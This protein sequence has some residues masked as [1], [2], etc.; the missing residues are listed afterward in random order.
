MQQK[1]LA[2]AFSI[3]ARVHPL[4]CPPQ[5]SRPAH[6]AAAAEGGEAGGEARVCAGLALLL[7]VDL[8]WLL[9][10]AG[11][12][13]V[14][15][16]R[17]SVAAAAAVAATTVAAAA[18]I[19]GR[20]RRRLQ[21]GWGTG[22]RRRSNSEV[23]SE[24][25]ARVPCMR[26]AAATSAAPAVPPATSGAPA[27]YTHVAVGS[28]AVLLLASRH[29][30][31]GGVALQQAR[32]EQ[33]SGHRWIRTQMACCKH[34]R[35]GA[36]KAAP[37]HRWRVASTAAGSAPAACHQRQRLG[38]PPASKRTGGGYASVGGGYCCVDGGG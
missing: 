2:V 23:A 30:G 13:A 25:L 18:R 37:G 20:S 29:A 36:G 6:H 31:R 33:E 10:V 34:S 14:V 27:A 19:A 28:A 21:Q 26:Q 16:R 22:S 8:L 32:V 3:A 35:S 17:R 15:R 5:A 9:L 12:R 24:A 7:H 4:R 38:A 1:L 11:R